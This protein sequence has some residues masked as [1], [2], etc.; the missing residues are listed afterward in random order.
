M[1]A[2]LA[3]ALDRLLAVEP[4]LR[5]VE[6]AGAA[7]GLRPRELLHAGPPL[8][9][10]R[11]PPPVLLSSAVVTT[12]HEGWAQDAQQAEAMV[13][14]GEITL[15]PAQPRGCVVPLAFVVAAGTPL[16]VIDDGL[17]LRMHAPVSSVRGSD[18]RMGHRDAGLG[19]R[20]SLRDQRI[21]P[22]WSEALASHGSLPLL[23]LA[24][25][26]LQDGDDLHSR[27]AAANAALSAWLRR[28]GHGQLADDI[29]ATPLFFLTLWMAACA[30]MLRSAEGGDQ[31]ALVTRAGG[32]GERFGIALAG[33]PESWT[34]I[35]A[36]PPAGRLLATVPAGSA[37]CGAIG[38]SA[39]IDMLGCG[40]M[41]LG[42]APEPAQAF[43]RLLPAGYQTLPDRLLHGFHPKLGRRVALDAGHV[44]E[45]GESPLVALAMLAADGLGGFAGRGLYRPAVALFRQAL[46]T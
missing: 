39:V 25:Q 28:H 24:A 37:L 30:L 41:A 42:G 13:R 44:V 22:A 4:Q 7:L 46:E 8:F 43:A 23:P 31:P 12:L 18:T 27:T 11:R 14:A 40:G 5:C 34:C 45:E 16:F 33:A 10:P 26:G 17:G 15:A 2:P 19:V 6:T 21:A 1:T 20:L 38:D 3:S 9:D 36:A 32:N 35:E 29:E